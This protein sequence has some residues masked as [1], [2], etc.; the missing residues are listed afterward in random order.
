MMAFLLSACAAQIWCRPT[1]LSKSYVEICQ[2]LIV[3][4]WSNYM[5][6][7]PIVRMV[8]TYLMRNR[9]IVRLDVTMIQNGQQTGVVTYLLYMY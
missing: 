4:L 8:I 3:G 6:S 7:R 2:C 1:K 9:P 5:R